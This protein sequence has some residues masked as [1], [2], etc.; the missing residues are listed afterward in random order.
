MLDLNN[1][2]E[3]SREHSAEIAEVNGL[4]D[5]PVLIEELREARYLLSW[6]LETPDMYELETALKSISRFFGE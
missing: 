4:C 6:I 2:E 3:Y 5:L 1:I